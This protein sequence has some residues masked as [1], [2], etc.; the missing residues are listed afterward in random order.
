MPA[1]GIWDLNSGFKGLI[2]STKVVMGPLGINMA[3]NRNVDLT[4]K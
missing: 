1:N 2:S 4:K 3:A